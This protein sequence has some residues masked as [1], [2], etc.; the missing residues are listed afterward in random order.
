MRFVITTYTS[1]NLVYSGTRYENI[2]QQPQNPSCLDSAS[3]VAFI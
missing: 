1:C 3:E 2:Y